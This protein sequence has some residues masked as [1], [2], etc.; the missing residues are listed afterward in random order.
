[1]ILCEVERQER[2]GLGSVLNASSHLRGLGSLAGPAHVPPSGGE[3]S[4]L[5]VL[6]IEYFTKWYFFVDF[7]DVLWYVININI[8]NYI[9]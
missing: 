9:L 7:A 8:A 5:T 4:S 2:F 6:G 1:M 3:R